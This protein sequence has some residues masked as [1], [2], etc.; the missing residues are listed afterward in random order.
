MPCRIC[1]Q[2]GCAVQCRKTMPP[3]LR[4]GRPFNARLADVLRRREETRHAAS[5]RL[6]IP[7]SNMEFTIRPAKR[8]DCPAMLELIRELAVYERAPD[9]VTV[10]LEH[11]E[12]C[13]FGEKP[14]WWA[15]VACA[16]LQQQTAA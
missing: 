16:P 11:F 7:L 9:E 13:G 4:C 12:E 10:S 3:L 15:Y 6:R 8:E 14:I 1:V 2:N 5:L